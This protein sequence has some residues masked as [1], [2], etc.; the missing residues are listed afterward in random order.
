MSKRLAVRSLL[1]LTVAVMACAAQEAPTLESARTSFLAG[2]YDEAEDAYR[3]L[4]EQ[5]PIPAQQGLL[6]TLLI[7]GEYT[8]AEEIARTAQ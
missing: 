5:S 1:G 2:D 7:V 6:Q 4:L 8:A 3:A